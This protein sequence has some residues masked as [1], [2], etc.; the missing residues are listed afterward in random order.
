MEQWGNPTD[1]R[2]ITEGLD[3]VSVSLTPDGFADSIKGEY[4]VEPL[5]QKM[6]IGDVI[7]WG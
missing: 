3:E 6:R 2:H 4:F 1:F 5:E 7:D